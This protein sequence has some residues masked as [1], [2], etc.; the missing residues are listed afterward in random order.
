MGLAATVRLGQLLRACFQIT[1]VRFSS[2]TLKFVFV[3]W[4]NIWELFL[5]FNAANPCLPLPTCDAVPRLL[6]LALLSQCHM[7]S[8]SPPVVHR[9]CCEAG[10]LSWWEGKPHLDRPQPHQ[11]WGVVLFQLQ[12]LPFQ[13]CKSHLRMH[14]IFPL[15]IALLWLCNTTPDLHHSKW[16]QSL[17]LAHFGPQCTPELPAR[18]PSACPALTADLQSWGH[19]TCIPAAGSQAQICG[20]QGV[21]G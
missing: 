5:N 9:E 10:R 18:H 15:F 2:P 17:I 20:A 16:E 1:A 4:S 8:I 19:S 13:G 12:Y 14:P 21:Q 6:L 3:P 7:F 11:I